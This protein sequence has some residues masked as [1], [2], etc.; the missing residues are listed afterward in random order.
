[1]TLSRPDTQVSKLYLSLSMNISGSAG[2][3]GLPTGTLEDGVWL[4]VV[5]IGD[6]ESSA[7]YLSSRVLSRSQSLIVYSRVFLAYN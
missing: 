7:N 5:L 1:M 6:L 3:G 4:V 2:L